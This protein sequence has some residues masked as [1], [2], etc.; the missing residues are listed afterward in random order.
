MEKNNNLDFLN[1]IY[2]T[3][4]M[5][6]VGINDVI[7]KASKEEFRDFLNKQREEY[8]KIMKKA[9]TLFTSYGM[10]EKE[11]S[12]FTKVNS[13]VMSEM[14]LITN[15]SD[16]TIAKMMMEGTNKGIIKINKTINENENVDNEA[17]D[18]AK[19]LLEIMEHNIDELKIYL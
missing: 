15:N 11:L 19:E 9:E 8:N 5:G 4:E 7:D 16:Q 14:K 6:I 18:L 2:K 12:T 3:S 1:V 10:K 13:K 17:L